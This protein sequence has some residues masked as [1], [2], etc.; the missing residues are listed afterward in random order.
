MPTHLVCLHGAGMILMMMDDDDD[1]NEDCC[2]SGSMKRAQREQRAEGFCG[3][4]LHYARRGNGL[5][6]PLQRSSS[7]WTVA[8][9]CVAAAAVLGGTWAPG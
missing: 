5:A 8:G 2:K 4:R 3:P 1:V 6:L 7:T 9:W